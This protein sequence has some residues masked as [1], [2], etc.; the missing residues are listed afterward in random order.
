MNI[1]ENPNLVPFAE[2]NTKIYV[3]NGILLCISIFDHGD[4][5]KFILLSIFVSMNFSSFCVGSATES[6]FL[7][8]CQMLSDKHL[9][10]KSFCTLF[11]ER[12][13]CLFNPKVKGFLGEQTLLIKAEHFQSLFGTTYGSVCRLPL[14]E[15]SGTYDSIFMSWPCSS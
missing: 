1:F 5:L 10:C 12:F 3:N 6:P 11:P 13:Y 4:S 14:M 8:A 9:I 7:S 2:F 15:L